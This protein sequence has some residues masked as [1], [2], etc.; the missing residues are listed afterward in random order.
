MAQRD[1]E[2]LV[3]GRHLEVE[4][5]GQLALEPGDVGIRDVAPVLAQVR[6]D[7]VGARLDGQMRGAQG[8][9]MPAAARV[10]DGGDVID[11]DAKAEVGR[12]RC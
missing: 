6:G 2:H 10:A 4:R 12:R 3:G 7:A 5:P 1:G 11:V 9:G 8:V